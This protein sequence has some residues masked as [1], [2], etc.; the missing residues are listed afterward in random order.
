MNRAGQ[1]GDESAHSKLADLQPLAGGR[2][3]ESSTL[4][5]ARIGGEPMKRLAIL[6]SFLPVLLCSCS[7]PD[8]SV[9]VSSAVPPSQPSQVKPAPTTAPTPPKVSSPVADSSSKGATPPPPGIPK[10]SATL[11]PKTGSAKPPATRTAETFAKVTGV[12]KVDAIHTTIPVQ[13]A[14]DK[15][16][17]A[18]MRLSIEK[19]GTYTL[20]GPDAESGT[21]AVEGL[22]ITL[23]SN[24]YGLRPPFTLSADGKSLSASSPAG[25]LVM[26]KS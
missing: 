22:T 13:N 14:Q 6:L 12:W 18:S 25:T 7:K 10:P 3:S 24:K 11:P 20:T 9:T 4:K 21:W 1:S 26:I 17:R 16:D 23:T 15:K 5:R 2:T 19:G 8:E